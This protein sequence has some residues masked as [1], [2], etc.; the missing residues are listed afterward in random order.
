MTVLLGLAAVFAVINGVNDGGAMLAATLKV[1]GLRIIVSLAMFTV[2]LAVVPLLIGTGVADTLT[3]G[4]VQADADARPRLIAVGVVAAV[5]VVAALTRSGLPT[6][7]TLAMVGGIVGAGVGRGLPV[8]VAGVGRVLAIGAAAPVVGGMLALVFARGVAWA[9]AVTRGDRL[10]VLHRVATAIQAVAYAANDGQKM[11]AVVA[12]TSLGVTLPTLVTV[13][14]LFAIGAVIG[15]GAAAETLGGQIL[16]AGPRE[17]L[18][19]QFA[20]SV[21]VL[22]S[23]ALGAPVS[24]TQAVTGGLVGTGMLRGLRQVRWRVAQQLVLAWIVTLPSAALVG[25][26]IAW[27][28]GRMA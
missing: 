12:V 6:S 27:F 2:A 28:M 5:T 19:A 13:A 18:T 26:G 22:A 14:G 9:L 1:P 10:A 4:L 24:M 15:V 7:L 8:A 3:S 20:A 25:T 17:E 11:L 21:A 23:A 16:R